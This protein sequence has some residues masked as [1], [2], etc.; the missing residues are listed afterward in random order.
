MPAP[1]RPNPQQPS[2]NP[3]DKAKDVAGGVAHPVETT[4]GLAAEAERGRTARTP[5]IA[6][7]GVTIVVGVVVALVLAVALILYFTL[8]GGTNH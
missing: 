7:T 1:E 4:K 2:L 6:I 8:G 3:V 5:L